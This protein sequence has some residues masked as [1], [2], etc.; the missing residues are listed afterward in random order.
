M[1]SRRACT[2]VLAFALLAGANRPTAPA[3]AQVGPPPPEPAAPCA[4]T[5]ATTYQTTLTANR[6]TYLNSAAV[7]TNYGTATSV[8]V[9]SFVVPTSGSY[10]TLAGFDL[11][12]LPADAVIVTATLELY[13]ISGSGFTV[14]AQALT[15]A[16]AETTVT[17]SNQPTYT[18]QNE[19]VGALGGDGWM[20]WDL[21]P[22]V[23]KWHAGT[24]ANHGV[25]LIFDFGTTNTRV[26]N[27]RE[28]GTL[29]P[30]LVVDYRRALTLTAT[31]DTQVS[32]ANP[33]SNSGT[34]VDMYVV[35][36][37]GTNFETHALVRFNTASLPANSVIHSATLAAFGTINLMAPEV[38]LSVEPHANLSSW[39]ETTVT[40]NTKPTATSQGDL[41]ATYVPGNW[42]FWEVRQTVQA[43]ANGTLTNNGFSLKPVSG[44]TGSAP[45]H[46]REMGASVTPRLFITYGPPVCHAPTSANIGGVTEGL[47]NT[48]YS[49]NASV[50]PPDFTLPATFTWQATGQT[51]V[52]GAN[53]AVT[54]SWAT[55]GT[56]TITVTVQNCGGSVQDTHQVVISPPVPACP[57][58]LT[59]LSLVGPTTGYTGTAY[60]FTG[61]VSP[62][63]ATTPIT[64]TWQ[65]TDHSPTSGASATRSFSW[66]TPGLKAITATA[67]NCG[68]SVT[69]HYAVQVQARPD[70]VISSVWHNPT[71]GRVYFV[72]QNV[73]AG[74]APAGHTVQVTQNGAP[75]ATTTFGEALPPGAVRAGSVAVAWACPASTAQLG[76]CADATGLIPESD[77][78]NNC[79]TT[80]WA[81]DLYPPQFTTGP[82]VTARTETTA[83][84]SWT[85]NEAAH[86]AFTWGRN[87]PFD[88]QTQANPTPATS[89]QVNLTGL[90]G[91]ATYWYNVVITDA[92][93]NRASSGGAF[94]QTEPP[95]TDPVTLGPLGLHSHPH[96]D[97]DFYTL[98]AE[99]LSNPAGVDRVVFFLDGQLMG[100]AQTPVAGGV[101]EVYLSPAARGWS[102]ADW[103]KSHTLQVQA[104]N[105]EGEVTAQMSTVTPA[106]STPTGKTVIVSPG[107]NYAM[108]APDLPLPPGT[109][110][111]VQAYGAVYHWRCTE[112]GTTSTPLPTGLAGVDCADVRA[113]VDTLKLYLNNVLLATTTPTG[114]L[115]DLS[116]NLAGKP[117]GLYTLRL[118]AQ[119]GTNTYLDERAFTIK[120][121]L[122]ELAYNRQVSVVGNVFQVT[123]WV[124]NTGTANAYVDK[125]E[126]FARGFQVVATIGTAGSNTY[127]VTSNDWGDT[128]ERNILIDLASTGNAQEA[129]LAAGEAVQVQYTLVPVLYP[130][131]ETYYIG[132]GHAA[133]HRSTIYYRLGGV[134]GNF[135][136]FF[137]AGGNR[138]NGQLLG[139]VVRQTAL[140]QA[141]YLLVTS[142][143]GLRHFTAPI[144]WRASA[145]TFR[146]LNR[147]LERMAE[148]AAVRH[149]ALAFAPINPRYEDLDAWLE[150]GG[151]WAE[152]LHPNFRGY[153]ATGYVLLVGETEVIPAQSAGYDVPYSDLRY[154]ST[155]GQ[156]KPELALGRM[157]GNDLGTLSQGLYTAIAFHRDGVGFDRSHALGASGTDSD[158]D[159][160]KNIFWGDIKAGASILTNNGGVPTEKIRWAT[161]N[162]PDMFTV[163]QTA[164]AATHPD[165]IFY[166]GH[167]S[168]QGWSG[169]NTGQVGL[170]DFGTTRPIGLGFACDT[171]HFGPPDSFSEVWLRSNGA[172]YIGS[173]S[174]SRDYPDSDAL[175]GF[176]TRWELGE[177]DRPVGQ[178]FTFLKRDK[179]SI[180]SSWKMF[181][182]QYHLFGDPTYG[183]LPATRQAQP[184][185]AAST[186]IT[187]LNV[188]VPPFVVTH[189]DGVD[190]VE[191]PA[192]EM[193]V[194][195]GEYRVPF[196]R[197]QLTY[198]A[199]QRVAA[200]TVTNQGGLSV[201]TG[202]NIL[203]NT[204]GVRC[205]A[206]APA[207][208]TTATGWQ[209]AV[210]QPFAWQVVD[211]P[212]GTSTLDLL[213][214]PFYYDPATTDAR[215]YAD[216]QFDLE[217]LPTNLAVSVHA[218]QAIYA[219][220]DPASLTVR[221][222]TSGAAQTVW[223]QT[224][225][226]TLDEVVVAAL[227]V[228]A[229]QQVTGTATLSLNLPPLPAGTYQAEVTVFDQAGRTLAVAYTEVSF[230]VA[231]VTATLTG[232]P[233]RFDP[234]D[235]I[236]LNLTVTNTGDVPLNGALWLRV[237]SADDLELLNEFTTTLSALAPGASASFAPAW[238]S[239][240]APP[241]D[242]RVVGYLTFEPGAA[243][244]P[245]E[246][247]LTTHH[248]LYLPLVQR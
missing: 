214:Y 101:F 210:P 95:G 24:Q 111:P 164:V 178:V 151:R 203:T 179:W 75:L 17:W 182:Y 185:L 82:T 68:G 175:R 56:K 167:G 112:N 225:I 211:N 65:A 93:G 196:W 149:G 218:G 156:A 233:H 57:N 43:W 168:W 186:I 91:G 12:P 242:Y 191:I 94:F 144:T 202:L 103:F 248:R 217:V 26:F 190:Q 3:A 7:D 11:A 83:I 170:L 51:P 130:Q 215:F 69:Q 155:S 127:A 25:R 145:G 116:L 22:L 109:T 124:S 27:A 244:A 114:L 246:L 21:T 66:E 184:T 232:T 92:A 150:P 154:A 70:L 166:S 180:D 201:T 19:T 139:D 132:S 194:R 173:V 128:P 62:A 47:T 36:A 99:V 58:P 146:E 143:A 61:T 73:G 137:Q 195:A 237:A 176:M 229:V 84:I 162:T 216:W 40:W 235:L 81:C 100:R 13:Q 148:L 169:L 104:Y 32:Q 177:E 1:L 96:P 2:F 171:G 157:V 172:V 226:R 15:S 142:P 55:T 88:T 37:S 67:Q 6:D 200:V 28:A 236:D 135:L 206:C 71:E 108:F 102:R 14:K 48:Q 183:A 59:G 105:L 78:A 213:I 46:T 125:V 31:A 23:Q 152:A 238:D 209:P 163:L 38:E 49:F 220:A 241:G 52:V 205:V 222:E 141:D 165:L 113:P 63:N 64:Y 85:T 74:S 129:V 174:P 20:R 41:A 131:N 107:A 87:G 230:G 90:T 97:F 122:A 136:A 42:T 207:A 115:A 53:S 60:A 98:R 188:T 197:T 240:G 76:V 133:T 160:E 247:W 121:G 30:R 224:L 89:G 10:R 72:I 120:Q 228:Q 126:D 118:T 193:W 80:T 212:D 198:P 234:G 86:S 189:A 54:Y 204:T 9:G 45:F 4:T 140:K 79:L 138:V 123:L 29:M 245:A 231:Q 199:G 34:A 8:R 117:A 110:L 35:R 77:E 44:Q 187:T 18:T 181:G 33:T 50:T 208:P 219:L 158:G 227:P 243:S 239:T 223:V 16:W 119:S 39:G 147:V 161:D 159:R 106:P 5:A 134:T 221:L 153:A 192:G